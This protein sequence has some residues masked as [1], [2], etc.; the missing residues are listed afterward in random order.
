MK[1][2][3]ILA[4]IEEAMKQTKVLLTKEGQVQLSTLKGN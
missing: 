1:N 3:K 2:E 4:I